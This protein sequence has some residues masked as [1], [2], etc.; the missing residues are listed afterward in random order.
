MR[1]RA[2][3]ARVATAS[4]PFSRE[5]QVSLPSPTSRTNPSKSPKPSKQS[6]S[7]LPVR[8][9]PRR[10]VAWFSVVRRAVIIGSGPMLR[11]GRRVRP[12]AMVRHRNLELQGDAAQRPRAVILLDL[13]A[14][15]GPHACP[16]LGAY[17]P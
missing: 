9:G 8:P 15:E 10:V 5:R 17:L 4:T 3:N 16:E 12:A 13:D 7:T 11:A 2:S 6:L 14:A 1:Q